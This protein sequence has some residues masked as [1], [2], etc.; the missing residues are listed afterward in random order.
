[1]KEEH[2]C[3]FVPECVTE[4]VGEQLAGGGELVVWY[5]SRVNIELVKAER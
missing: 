2:G 4:A 1:M 3:S 5:L